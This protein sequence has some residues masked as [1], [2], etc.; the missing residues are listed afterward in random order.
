MDYKGLMTPGRF[1]EPSVTRGG[2]FVVSG[3]AGNGDRWAF[4]KRYMNDVVLIILV[5][6]AV[7]LMEKILKKCEELASRRGLGNI[8]C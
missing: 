2:S 1:G 4:M 6:V 3:A 7:H 8:P 5:I